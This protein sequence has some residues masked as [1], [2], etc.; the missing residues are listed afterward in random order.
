[1][2]ICLIRL[3]AYSSSSSVVV[4]GRTF[5]R[6]SSSNSRTTRPLRRSFSISAA[7][8]QIIMALQ[9]DEE[10]LTLP[11]PAPG[12]RP[13][14]AE[15]LNPDNNRAMVS[16][17]LRIPATGSGSPT[18]YRRAAEQE[19]C[20]PYRTAPPCAED[21]RKYCKEFASAGTSGGPS[22]ASSTGLERPGCWALE[23]QAGLAVGASDRENGPAPD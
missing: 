2:P 8:L 19:D 22:A 10:S 16:S 17:G 1:M 9:G 4:P 18:R 7:L 12:R 15:G 13:P 14:R 23:A 20:H 11:P 6:I 3:S 21:C 5:C